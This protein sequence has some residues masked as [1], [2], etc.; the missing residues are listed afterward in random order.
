MMEY[1]SGGVPRWLRWLLHVVIFGIRWLKCDR[2]SPRQRETRIFTTGLLIW[3]AVQGTLVNYPLWS[4]RGHLPEIDEYYGYLS[5]SPQ[6][7]TCFF[8]DCPALEDL[9]MQ[10]HNFSSGVDPEV[11]WHRYR[12]YTRAFFVYHPL[13]TIIHIGITQLLG[14]SWEAAYRMIWSVMPVVF[15]V[16]FGFLLSSIWGSAPAGIALGMLAFQVFP[17]QGLHFVVPSN[18]ALA[19]AALLWAH[20]IARQGRTPRALM[21][22]VLVLVLMHPIGCVYTVIAAFLMLFLAGFPRQLRGWLPFIWVAFLVG[23][24]FL[25]PSLT[26]RPELNIRTDPWPAGFRWQDAVILALI[27]IQDAVVSWGRGVGSIAVASVGVLGGL[28]VVGRERRH[29]ALALLGMLIGCMLLS[30]SYVYARYPADLLLRLWVPTAI[31]LTGAIGAMLW[32][33]IQ[34]LGALLMSNHQ[35]LVPSPPDAHAPTSAANN[36][37]IGWLAGCSPKTRSLLVLVGLGGFFGLAFDVVVAGQAPLE[38]TMKRMREVEDVV[39]S[40]RQP[41]LLLERAAP[42]DRVIYFDEIP[43]IFYLTHGALHLGA[44]H[45]PGIKGTPEEAQWLGREDLH[46]AVIWDPVESLVMDKHYLDIGVI[47]REGAITPER[48]LWMDLELP[49]ATPPEPLSFLV[50]NSGNAAAVTAIPYGPDGKP[51]PSIGI[52][53]TIPPRTAGRVTLNLDQWPTSDAIPTRWQLR[54]SGHTRGVQVR[55]MV[56]GDDTRQ[57]PWEQR[58]TLHLV[59]PQKTSLDLMHDLDVRTTVTIPFDPKAILPTLL[60]GRRMTVLDDEGATVLIQLE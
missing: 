43:R 20:I 11:A 37:R 41:T 24:A 13:L 8:Q 59:T 17:V 14:V 53:A 48:L 26:D 30:L 56:F 55:G 45:Y 54:F 60:A 31:L 9:R 34:Q 19:I 16:A 2:L 1:Q 12:A 6:M 40:T 29:L 18:M 3:I 44:I 28:W 38:T 7:L 21:V 57:W 4:R 25:L 50:R 58:A 42:G 15:G 23:V 51:V 49:E 52:T 22:G 35:L 5:R 39:L 27:A 36:V 10:L 46:F 47:D 33:L 32:W